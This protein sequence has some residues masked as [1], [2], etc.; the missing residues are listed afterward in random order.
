MIK[1]VFRCSAALLALGAVAACSD[2]DDVSRNL[3]NIGTTNA[4]QARNGLPFAGEELPD[5]DDLGVGESA[6]VTLS[7]LRVTQDDVDAPATVEL[8]EETITLTRTGDGE[9]D[10]TLTVTYGGEEL[11]FDADSDGPPIVD[12]KILLPSDGRFGTESGLLQIVELSEDEEDL[13][14]FGH[15]IAGFET[16]P[17]RIAEL[18]SSIETGSVIYFGEFIGAATRFDIDGN[19]IESRGGSIVTVSGDTVIEASFQDMLVSGEIGVSADVGEGFNFEVG[20][21]DVAIAGNGFETTETT[22]SCNDVITTCTSDT[23]LGGAFFGEDAQD[24]GGLVTFDLSGFDDGDNGERLVGG[25]GFSA[26]AGED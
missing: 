26:T 6:S 11:V 5:I 3:L 9:E 21:E 18:G 22:V 12:G 1:S 7:L 10:F 4:E 2:S 20:F 24:V 25:G 8:T 19:P 16:D 23:Q 14:G 15:V 17:D 13:L